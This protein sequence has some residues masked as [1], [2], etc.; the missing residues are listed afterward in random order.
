MFGGFVFVP[1][2]ASKTCYSPEEALSHLNKDVCVA[3]HVYDVV[4]LA[5]GSRFLDVCS[6]DTS[7]EQCRFTV[8]SRMEIARKWAT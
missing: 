2:S 3:A 7:D 8:M 6:P 5:D 4:E 1:L